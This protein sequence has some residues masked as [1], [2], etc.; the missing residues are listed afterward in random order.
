M[1]KKHYKH[2]GCEKELPKLRV[3]SSIT[4]PEFPATFPIIFDT[5]MK[6]IDWDKLA[7]WPTPSVFITSY[8]NNI[9]VGFRYVFQKVE[10]A[11]IEKCDKIASDN[12]FDLESPVY[13]HARTKVLQ[14]LLI[15]SVKRFRHFQK[16]V[17]RQMKKL[18]SYS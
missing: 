10:I 11:C 4:L 6:S 14:K 16:F 17:K 1:R 13:L 5:L 12:G 9:E 15:K 18:L 7:I 2:C 8:D 3:D